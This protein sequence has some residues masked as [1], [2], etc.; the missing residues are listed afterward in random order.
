MG[1]QR[2]PKPQHDPA[3]EQLRTQL[4]QMR[5]A[6][7]LTQEALAEC[8]GR[9]HTFIHKIESGDRRIDPVEFCRWCQACDTLP[10]DK[11]KPVAK[12]SKKRS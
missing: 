5:L 7:D 2:R 3:Y 8:F 6:A 10:E 12:A 9:P 4:K 1:N 11:I